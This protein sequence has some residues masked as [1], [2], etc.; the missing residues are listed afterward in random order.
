M[1]RVGGPQLSIV[2]HEYLRSE[3]EVQ[4]CDT[5]DIKFRL[6]PFRICKQK[7]GEGSIRD[8]Y[9]Q[10]KNTMNKTT[11]RRITMVASNEFMC[12]KI[13]TYQLERSLAGQLSIKL[14]PPH[15]HKLPRKV[16]GLCL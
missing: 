11:R 8:K 12:H 5:Y 2:A 3:N 15:S 10:K 1:N 13:P 6:E 16:L 4:L 9:Q 7:R 14:I